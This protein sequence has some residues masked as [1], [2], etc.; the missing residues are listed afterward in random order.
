MDL[1]RLLKL[2]HSKRKKIIPPHYNAY[3]AGAVQGVLKPKERCTLPFPGLAPAAADSS[4]ASATKPQLDEQYLRTLNAISVRARNQ[5][6]ALAGHWHPIHC[7]V[8][9]S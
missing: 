5:Q 4:K 6:R 8:P 7:A 3:L 2:A 1:T 9:N